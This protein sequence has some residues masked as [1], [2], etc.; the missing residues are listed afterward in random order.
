MRNIT[1]SRTALLGLTVLA[2]WL[3]ASSAEERQ[4]PGPTGD[5][6]VAYGDDWQSYADNEALFA[7]RQ[8]W[9]FTRTPEKQEWKRHISLVPDRTFKQVVRMTQPKQDPETAPRGGRTFF[10]TQKFSEPMG[11]VWV[12]FRVR[13]SPSW[14]AEGSSPG[15]ANPAYKLFFLLFHKADGRT[16][17]EFAHRTQYIYT[18]LQGGFRRQHEESFGTHRWGGQVTGEFTNGEWYEYVVHREVTG[19]TSYVNRFYRRQLTQD[20]TIVDLPWNFWGI[21]TVGEPGQ[22]A[23]PARA[24]QLGANKNKSNDKTQYICWG[25]WEVVDG[26]ECPNPYNLPLE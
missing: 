1:L 10:L 12:R 8:W 19:P 14:T 20:G 25:P 22:V 24:I 7:R 3:A 5:Y 21:R 4:A 2:A 6:V 13:F 18:N 16:G 26:S 11:N 15:Q 17:I 9:N 23:R